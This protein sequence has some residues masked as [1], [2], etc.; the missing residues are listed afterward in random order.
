MKRENRY[1]H[2]YNAVIYVKFVR[3]AFTKHELL[4]YINS[5]RQCT[6]FHETKINTN[7]ILLWWMSDVDLS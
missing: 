7:T 3:M 2:H 1:M 6:D 4:S 5:E